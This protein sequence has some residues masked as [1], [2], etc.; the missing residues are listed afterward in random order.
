M[1][2]LLALIS[3]L[4]MLA[5]CPTAIAAFYDG[6]VGPNTAKARLEFANGGVSGVLCV[7]GPGLSLSYDVYTHRRPKSRRPH[8]R[9]PVLERK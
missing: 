1:K 8:E 2:W 6:S 7:A 5:V 9:S 4:G 3:T